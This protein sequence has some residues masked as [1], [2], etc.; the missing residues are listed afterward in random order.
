MAVAAAE[1]EA[2]KTAASPHFRLPNGRGATTM[3]RMHPTGPLALIPAG[4]LADGEPPR[5]I[6]LAD[7]GSAWLLMEQGS[8]VAFRNLCPH[9]DAPLDGC[10]DETWEAASRLFVCSFHGATFSAQDGRCI[11]GPCRGSRL[12]QLEVRA[13]PAGLELHA[14]P[15]LNL[16]SLTP[17]PGRP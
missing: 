14:P 12:P 17:R 8:A 10:D 15:P 2:D 3:R 11:E 9:L 13:T 1:E 5:R 4:F 7:G 6:E 16:F